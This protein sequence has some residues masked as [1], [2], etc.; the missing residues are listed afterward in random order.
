MTSFATWN[1]FKQ[2]LRKSVDQLGEF[3]KDLKPAFDDHEDM[4]QPALVIMDILACVQSMLMQSTV[5]KSKLDDLRA[6]E[7][8]SCGV[9][10]SNMK[11]HLIA[12]CEKE[13]FA[14]IIPS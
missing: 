4:M 13:G 10:P 11:A 6:Y 8:V 14:A 12:A 1:H 3:S 2:S 5:T 9:L 7:A